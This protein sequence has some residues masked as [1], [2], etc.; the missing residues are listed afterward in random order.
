[1]VLGGGRGSFG[2]QLDNL[3]S[4]DIPP[5]PMN[6]DVTIHPPSQIWRF[7]RLGMDK[8]HLKKFTR[9]VG[10]SRISSMGMAANQEAALRH[11]LLSVEGG[12]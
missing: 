12:G 6:G 7:F 8:S 9:I 3:V 10:W 11:H 1:M 5:P 4:N 2:T